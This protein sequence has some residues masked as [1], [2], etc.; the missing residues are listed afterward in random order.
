MA[1]VRI[2]IGALAA[3]TFLLTDCSSAAP[4]ASSPPRPA[5]R[6]LLAEKKFQPDSFYTG[7]DRPED[8]A[9]LEN[10]VNGAVMDVAAL[11]DPIEADAV[12]RRLSKLIADTDSFATEDRDQIY[13]YAIRIWRA[14]GFRMQSGLFGVPDEKVMRK[15]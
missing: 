2:G 6:A 10:A 9:L 8:R 15:P 11:P 14:A 1:R 4:P 5:L 13:R 12:H 7:P 3:L